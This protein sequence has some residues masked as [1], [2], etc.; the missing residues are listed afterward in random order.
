MNQKTCMNCKW[1]DYWF[2]V[3]TNGDSDWC[4]DTPPEKWR[5]QFWEELEEHDESDMGS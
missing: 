3:C 5:C 1:L 2:G 4:A